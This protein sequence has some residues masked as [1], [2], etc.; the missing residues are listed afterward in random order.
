VAAWISL[1]DVR[2][3]L[4]ATARHLETL[5]EEEE[6]LVQEASPVQVLRPGSDAA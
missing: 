1:K 4:L 5:A 3:Q 2:E 6:R